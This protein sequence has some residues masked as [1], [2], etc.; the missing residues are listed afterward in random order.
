[1]KRN[2]GKHLWMGPGLLLAFTLWTVLILSVDVREAGPNETEIGLAALNLWFH[3]LTGVH[4]T[5]YAITDWLGLVPIAVCM[6][7]GVLGLIQLVRRKSL[8]RVDPD[9]VCLGI[10]YILV[11]LCYLL[12][13]AVPINY[14]PILIGGRLEASYPSSTTLLVL[15]VMPTLKLQAGRRSNRAAIRKTA[16]GF[17]LGFSSFMV[18]GRMVSGVHWISDIVGAVLL[19]LGLF[20]LYRDSVEAL[21]RR[22]EKKHGIQ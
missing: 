12:F 5:L 17:A 14:R 4:L 9:V 21:D 11:I 3:R 8:R 22:E 1:M 15:S 19:S 7:F 16:G 13:E 10:Y 6:G 20:F 18:V 2:V